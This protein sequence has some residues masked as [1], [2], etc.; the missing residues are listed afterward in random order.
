LVK[1]KRKMV[2]EAAQKY[3]A[4]NE[5]FV[6]EDY[7]S[8]IKFYTEAIELD[9]SKLEYYLKRCN[10]YIKIDSFKEAVKD[11]EL[12]LNIDAKNPKVHQRKGFAL[13]SLK[14]FDMALESY[15]YALELDKS[16][17]QTEQWIRKCEAEIDLK[18]RGCM[19]NKMSIG[20]SEP[21]IEPKKEKKE[22][23]SNCSLKASEPKETVSSTT[24]KE[25]P[26]PLPPSKIKYDW[27]Q[28]DTHIVISIMI[29]NQNANH[30]TCDF[31]AQTLSFG[32]KLISGSDYSLELDLAHEIVPKQ[33]SYRVIPAKVE[34]KMKK[35][36]GIRW[37][38][39]ETDNES[40]LANAAAKT[41]EVTE[42]TAPVTTKED[43][44]SRVYPTSA[45]KPRDW[46]R[47]EK[48]VQ[49][50]EKKENMEGEG[51]L[52]KLF[53][54]IYADGNEETRRAMNKSFQESGGT[55]LSTNWG[56]V[57]KDK[58]DIKPPDSMEW[59][60]YEY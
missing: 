3:S 30:I 5:A 37:S 10:A 25:D 52:N 16:N 4:G 60:K 15:R 44:V 20:L 56:E 24:P 59:K 27:Y 51:A 57:G 6:D 53:Q 39:L 32:A 11:A 18:K 28:T 14:D 21:V 19:K 48:E 55:V 7:D 54:Q 49:E 26:I 36:E 47:L 17:A 40:H 1:S 23:A 42:T 58:V 38:S 43:K 35:A 29:K 33:S 45:H 2:E 41:A 34:I 8:A 50:E 31:N 13:F 12:A 22:A 9:S 46:D